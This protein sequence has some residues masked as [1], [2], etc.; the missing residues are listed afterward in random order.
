MKILVQVL[1]LGLMCFDSFGN[2]VSITN[3]NKTSNTITFDLSWENSWRVGLTYHDAVWVFVKQAPNGG[4]SWEHANISTATVDAGYETIIP[5]DQ[6]GFFVRRS[7]NG[8]G[9]SITSV[10]ATLIGLSGAFQDV[11]V[12]GVEMV[13]VP[14]GSFY[15]GD[16]S[17]S[18]RIARGD[19][20]LES[21]HITS[22]AGLTCGTTSSDFQYSSGTCTNIPSSFPLGFNPFYSMKYV[23]TQSQYIDFLNCLSRSQQ[24]SRVAADV[25]GSTV[26]NV[27]VLC[28]NTIPIK[29]NVVRCDANIGTGNIN[30]YC[31][32]NNNGIPNEADDGLS[33]AC[34]YL[35]VTD[36]MAYLD[37]S[38]L[39]PFSFLEIEKASR[40]PSLPI[41]DEYSWGST[42][43]NIGGSVQNA[44]T[45]SENW[46]NSYI[47]GGISTYSQEVIRVGCNA[48]SSGASR[49]LSNASFY[50]IIDIGNNP[51]DFY[52]PNNYVTTYEAN[53]GDGVLNIAG[54][55]DV[56]SWPALDPE[57]INKIKISIQTSGIS[58]LGIGAIGRGPGSGGRG[59]R[60]GI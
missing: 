20:V 8:N 22:N 6:V 3:L 12:M 15:A 60:S 31:D 33:R 10:T 14:S 55:A 45:D 4:P 30:F 35:T 40:G 29:G 36:W 28:D 11:K 17:S 19:D 51:G 39:R 25:T 41:Q 49:E 23:I 53:E 43:W 46:S 37:W 24:E 50:G 48:P 13:Y 38:G 7:V 16:G 21:V 44:G 5:A 47:E 18:S 1:I 27:F 2:N 32:R 57:A 34:N 59:I 52:I 26:T 54:E 58:E 56:S 42:L 9:T